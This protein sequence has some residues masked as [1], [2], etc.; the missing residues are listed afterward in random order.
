MMSSQSES[1]IQTDHGIMQNKVKVNQA[2]FLMTDWLYI[3]LFITKK[4]RFDF[5]LLLY[6]VISLKIQL[7]KIATTD[8]AKLQY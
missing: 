6:L 2:L 5:I 3:I 8:L 1:S 4:Y 7:I